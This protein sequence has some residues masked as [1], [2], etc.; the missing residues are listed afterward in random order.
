MENIYHLFGNPHSKK[1][2]E[3]KKALDAIQCKYEFIER[4]E[5]SQPILLD[6][7]LTGGD[8]LEEILKFCKKQKELQNI[9][10][11]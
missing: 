7:E 6:N 1:V 3:A 9:S 10:R 4:T 11:H 5:L 8:N 2:T